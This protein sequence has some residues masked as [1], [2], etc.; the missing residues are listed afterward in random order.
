MG[1]TRSD[2]LI[3]N[4]QFAFKCE[5]TWDTLDRTP[6]ENVRFCSGCSREVY[7][8]SDDADLMLSIQLNRCVAVP[9]FRS[10]LRVSMLLGMPSPPDAARPKSSPETR[11]VKPR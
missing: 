6:E 5:A 9:Q 10:V 3:R 11:R 8:C 2:V 1:R 7:R 4:C